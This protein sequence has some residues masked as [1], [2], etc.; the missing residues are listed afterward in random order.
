[1]SVRR[2][3]QRAGGREG[4]GA[5]RARRMAPTGVRWMRR[6]KAC[7]SSSDSDRN[8]PSS[9]ARIVAAAQHTTSRQIQQARRH[10]WQGR[11]RAAGSMQ[12][13]ACAGGSQETEPSRSAAASPAPAQHAEE[14]QRHPMPKSGPGTGRT[15]RRVVDERR[16]WMDDRRRPRKHLRAA[17]LRLRAHAYV[18]L[19]APR[20]RS[21]GHCAV[22]CAAQLQQQTRLARRGLSP[23][24]A[25][26]VPAG[27]AGLSWCKA[28]ERRRGA[29]IF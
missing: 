16:R 25:A 23:T 20:C 24:Q 29:R 9:C 7:S 17:T 8:L 12:R 4:A 13:R 15:S 14:A 5:D 3:R 21:S 11:L 1:M 26:D 28:L 18:L 2:E 19:H 10:C 22:G 6:M 27:P